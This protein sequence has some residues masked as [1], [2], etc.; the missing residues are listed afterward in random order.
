MKN[1]LQKFNIDP[2]ISTLTENSKGNKFNSSLVKDGFKFLIGVVILFILAYLGSQSGLYL[3][4][5]ISNIILWIMALPLI[6]SLVYIV[7]GSFVYFIK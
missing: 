3:I 6:I 1:K 5:M 7:I 4:V 2:F